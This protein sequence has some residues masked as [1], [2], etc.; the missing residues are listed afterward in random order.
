MLNLGE[1]WFRACTHD[2]AVYQP[3]PTTYGEHI[4]VSSTAS[5]VVD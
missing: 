3:L 4:L 5:T 2:V 1:S